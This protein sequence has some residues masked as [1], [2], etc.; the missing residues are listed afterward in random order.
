MIP[1]WNRKEH[2]LENTR[3]MGKKR[4]GGYGTKTIR[5]DRTGIA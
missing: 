1:Y 5:V 3:Y 4:I 2:K